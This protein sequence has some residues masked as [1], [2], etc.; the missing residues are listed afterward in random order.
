M[1]WLDRMFAMS[2]L[3]RLVERAEAAE[4]EWYGSGAGNSLNDAIDAYRAVLDDGQAA[5]RGR[6]VWALIHCARLLTFRA[7][8]RGT[9]D[10]DEAVS[11]LGRAHALVSGRRQV[12]IDVDLGM[13]YRARYRLTRLCA[14]LDASG[15]CYQQV[16]DAPDSHPHDRKTALMAL[17]EVLLERGLR[18]RAA[19]DIEKAKALAEDAISLPHLP[20][21]DLWRAEE[22][23]AGALLD[24]YRL[25]RE[26]ADPA[27]LDHAVAAYSAAMRS[28]PEESRESDRL[29]E[30]LALAYELRFQSRR[31]PAD[32]DRC[33]EL[34]EAVVM[35][36]V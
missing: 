2:A 36:G 23:F 8:N 16:L 29:K 26:A 25:L 33:I 28:V 20:A 11:L 22:L 6:D 12:S 10:I 5:R 34:L 7:E 30:N 32:L 15:T 1:G 17:A 13:V 14:D 35:R 24:R 31:S 3:D 18:W 9:D 19:S 27:D 4:S 21:D